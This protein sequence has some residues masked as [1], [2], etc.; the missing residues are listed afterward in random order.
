MLSVKEKI[1]YGLGDTA[2][3]II[4]QTV[5]LFLTF[6]YTDIFGISAA[7]VGTMFLVVRIMDAV[8][9]PLM[10]YLADRTRSR[11]GRYRPY[12]LWCALPFAV[13]SV[14]AFTTPSL[15][16]SG[17]EI[18]ALITY[19]LLML[20]YTAINI[21][22]CALGAALTTNPTE[23]VS[24][25]SYRFVFAMLGGLI[26]TA[27]TLPLVDF[28]GHG[29]KA[30]G[31]QLT[32]FAMSILGTVMFLLCFAGTKE[33]D[34]STDDS[35]DNLKLATKA[36]WA[37]DQWRVLSAAAIFLLTGLV[38]KSTLA[39]YYVKYFLG[40]EDMIS[41]FVTSGVVGNLVGVALAQ[42]LADKVCK[43]KAYIHLQLIAA[44]LCVVAWFVPGDQYLLALG[45]Y[46]AWNFSINMGTPLL[47][48]K[49]A[50]TVDYGQFKTGVRT[51][52]LVYSSI[53][54]FIKL[55]L[56]IGGALAGW[57]LAAYGYQVDVA[58]TPETLA[59][60]LLCFTLYPALASVAVAFVMGR[61]TLDNQRVAEINSTLKQ[62]LSVT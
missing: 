33:R 40:R 19:A 45:L 41:V 31:Y 54:F 29:D 59:G 44:A 26:V 2:S 23:R 13:I 7:F 25:Q 12:L 36:L 52:G 17:K 9:D 34:F 35:N 60:I 48:A 42:K 28:F 62:K 6:F 24:V 53:I 10:G 8:T 57:L 16:E 20:A 11:W 15:S 4:F 51:T 47:W 30:K 39:I 58:Q 3:N 32:I 21:P 37:N 18:Y 43:V 55:G 22:Y 56:A 27:L 61:Y 49:M 46:I 50:D 5:M 1:A 14:L 38:L